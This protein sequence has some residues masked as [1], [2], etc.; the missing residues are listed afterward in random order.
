[1]N[2]G[3]KKYGNPAYWEDGNDMLMC[4]LI[5]VEM[6]AWQLTSRIKQAISS[7]Q[8]FVQR[9]FLG[10]EQPRVEVSRT[11]QQD[12]ASD[13]SW[14]QWKWMKSYRIWEANRKVFLY[15]ENWIEPELRD[16]KSP[17]FKELESELLQAEVTT[18]TAE[19]ALGAYLEKL[20]T[21]SQLHICG[22]YEQTD[23]AA[24]EKRESVLHVF[25]HTFATP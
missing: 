21:V 25:G 7:T 16:D 18:D 17:F 1:M 19:A 15:P 2:Q 11:E 12:T 5:E 4:F 3:G 23:F 14:K 6:C 24:D 8:M 20:D 13:N 22:M 10:L 9:C